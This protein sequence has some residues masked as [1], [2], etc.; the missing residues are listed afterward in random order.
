MA[1]DDQRGGAGRNRARVREGDA[2]PGPPPGA[3]DRSLPPPVTIARVDP[4]TAGSQRRNGACSGRAWCADASRAADSHRSGG[5]D[6][7]SAVRASTAE[8]GAARRRSLAAAA[9]AAAASRG[10]RRARVPVGDD[11]HLRRTARPA[12]ELHPADDLSPEIR[13][14]AVPRRGVLRGRRAGRILVSWVSP[15][16]TDAKL[17]SAPW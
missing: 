4:R 15:R 14:P 2:P 7:R 16:N 10:A 13:V 17:G 3:A 8:A 5:R 12:H 11:R 6:A 9:I 1:G